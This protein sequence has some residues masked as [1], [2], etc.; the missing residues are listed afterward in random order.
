MAVREI[1]LCCPEPRLESGCSE[2]SAVNYEF[3]QLLYVIGSLERIYR[4]N[5][6]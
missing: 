6:I 2:L 5:H 1:D 3:E 4:G